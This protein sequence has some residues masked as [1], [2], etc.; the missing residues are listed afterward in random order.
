M[1]KLN[2]VFWIALLIFL[3]STFLLVTGSEWLLVE[4]IK[5]PSIPLGSI[6]TALGI[7]ALHVLVYTVIQRL[8]VVK[9]WESVFLGILFFSFVLAIGWLPLGRFLSGNWSNS[10]FNQP[11]HSMIFWNYTY[12][13][14]GLPLFVLV[15]FLLRFLWLRFYKN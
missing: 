6:S 8:T 9:I 3:V 4:L 15:F 2:W 5:S 14:V 13:I 10:F 7:I 1:R 12:V 11:V